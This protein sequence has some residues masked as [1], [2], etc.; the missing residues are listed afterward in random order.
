MKYTP[1]S[2]Q[3]YL[4]MFIALSYWY[5]SS[6]PSVLDPHQNSPS[7][8]DSAA[9][10]LQDQSLPTLWQVIHSVDAGVDQ[11]KVLNVGLG[12]S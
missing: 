6:M 10:V 7:L 11:L 3:L 5:D 1:L 4:Q 12:C 9:M 2:N 8:R